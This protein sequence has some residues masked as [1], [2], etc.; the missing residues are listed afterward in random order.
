M[1]LRRL[2]AQGFLTAL[3][4]DETPDHVAKCVD[5]AHELLAADI[6]GVTKQGDDGPD[7]VARA[8]WKSHPALHRQGLRHRL[9]HQGWIVLKVDGRHDL[10]TRPGQTN[11]ALTAFERRRLFGSNRLPLVAIVPAPLQAG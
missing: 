6:L 7:V 5:Q 9:A 2:F 8:H 4:L 11:Q 1:K 3:A 10:G